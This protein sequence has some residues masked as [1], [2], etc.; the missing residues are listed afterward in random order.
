MITISRNV[1]EGDE[2]AKNVVDAMLYTIAK[3]IGAMHVALV[4]KVDAIIFTGGI[5]YDTYCTDR[6]KAQVEYIA[7]VVICPGEDEMALL[8]TTPS[9]HSGERCRCSSTRARICNRI[10]LISIYAAPHF[11]WCCVA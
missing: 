5:A 8:P 11:V 2:H 4:G 6:L 10:L 1:E 3:Q 7:P 9:E